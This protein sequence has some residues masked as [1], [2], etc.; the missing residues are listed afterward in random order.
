MIVDTSALPAILL[1]EPEAQTFAEAIGS[2]LSRSAF[3]GWLLG[4]L[5]HHRPRDFFSTYAL[6]LSRQSEP[7]VENLLDQ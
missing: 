7:V 1:L 5:D 2:S 4:C 6:A 3:S